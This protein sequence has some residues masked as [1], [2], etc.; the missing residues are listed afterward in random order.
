MNKKATA[1]L[2]LAA[3]TL[4]GC[5]TTTQYTTA[6]DYDTAFTSVSRALPPAGYRD[7][8]IDK[9]AGT[10]N[11]TA[12][13]GVGYTT[14]VEVVVTKTN[15]VTITAVTKPSGMG[16]LD[17]TGN[18]QDYMDKELFKTLRVELKDVEVKANK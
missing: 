6:S 17:I 2:A 14:K 4:A 15:P 13:I 11:G 18:A 10:I 9:A 16:Y 5:S 12:T 8:V 7:P 3:L 1:F